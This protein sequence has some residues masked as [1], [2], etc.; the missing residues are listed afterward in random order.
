MTP[1]RIVVARPAMNVINI[2]DITTI[3]FEEGRDIRGL[4]FEL[5]TSDAFRYAHRYVGDED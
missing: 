5:V 2:D 4:M 3:F 1:L